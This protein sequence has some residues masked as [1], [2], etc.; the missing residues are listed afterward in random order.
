M[1]LAGGL[2]LVDLAAASRREALRP[3]AVDGADGLPATV[4]HVGRPPEAVVAVDDPVAGGD[5][6]VLRADARDIEEALA[7][8]VD[9]DAFPVRAAVGALGDELAGRADVSRRPVVEVDGRDRRPATGFGDLLVLH[10]A[11]L[12]PRADEQ[13]ARAV[14]EVQSFVGPG[15]PDHRTAL[16][17]AGLLLRRGVVRECLGDDVVLA[18]HAR[19]ADEPDRLPVARRVHRP[20][21]SASGLWTVL[22]DFL[23]AVLSAREHVAARADRERSLDGLDHPVERLRGRRVGLRPAGFRG[24]FRCEPTRWDADRGD[25]RRAARLQEAASCL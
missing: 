23:P 18:D 11:V 6:H 21:R 7:R 2:A 3:V 24:P 14:D 5:G 1:P 10:R 13:L 19:P 15:F 22:D 4:D 9:P 17:G 12:L 25:R 8:E 16:P 20:E